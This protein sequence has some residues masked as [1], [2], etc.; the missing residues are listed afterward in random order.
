MSSYAFYLF[1]KIYYVPG[2]L[3]H[4]VEGYRQ[5]TVI[6]CVEILLL[7]MRMG[8]EKS[9]GEETEWDNICISAAA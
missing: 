8:F 7:R 3:A 1:I 5:Q 6:G 4:Y 2:S 9:G